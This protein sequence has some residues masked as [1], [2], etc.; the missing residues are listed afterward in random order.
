MG[1]SKRAKRGLAIFNHIQTKTKSSRY[2]MKKLTM[3]IDLNKV[4]PGVVEAGLQA[5][6]IMKEN[7]NAIQKLS[8][9][10]NNPVP[11]DAEGRT[12]SDIPVQPKNGEEGTQGTDA[13]ASGGAK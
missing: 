1:L 5:I 9:S 12:E 11:A 4:E 8:E 13:G 7:A 2:H 6:Q 10:K 3:M